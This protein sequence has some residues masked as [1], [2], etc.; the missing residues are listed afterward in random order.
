M[1]RKTGRM[2]TF[3]KYI[4]PRKTLRANRVFVCYI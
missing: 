3:C 1:S 2:V 4:L